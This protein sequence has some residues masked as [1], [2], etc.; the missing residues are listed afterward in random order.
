M[1]GAVAVRQTPCRYFFFENI[2]LQKVRNTVG[3]KK[4]IGAILTV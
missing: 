4:L 1:E 3:A 2:L